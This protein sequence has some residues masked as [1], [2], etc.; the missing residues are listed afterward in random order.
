MIPWP[1]SLPRPSSKLVNSY[2][3]SVVST[4]MDS[5]L[6]RQRR[7]GTR[8]RNEG[9][10]EWL[11]T[12]EEFYLFKSYVEHALNGGVS[13]FQLPIT[14]GNGVKDHAVT[15]RDGKYKYSY[16][17]VNH[18]KV[19]ANI[20]YTELETMTPEEVAEKLYPIEEMEPQ[21]DY[22]VNTQLPEEVGTPNG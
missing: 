22:I 16:Q 18:W 2:T 8:A 11:F 3:P 5:G 21:L 9:T 13:E 14:T 1:T 17:D 10:V 7:R 6:V 12:E 20:Y 15:F 19:S 4:K